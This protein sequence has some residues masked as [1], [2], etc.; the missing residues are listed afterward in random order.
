[1]TLTGY[2]GCPKDAYPELTARADYVSHTKGDEGAVRDFIEPI[3]VKRDQWKEA[4]NKAYGVLH[5]FL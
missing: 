1:M 2:I 4:V 3:L 5:E